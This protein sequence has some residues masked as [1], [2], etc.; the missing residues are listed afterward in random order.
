MIGQVAAA[1]PGCFSVQTLA[2]T[3]ISSAR[4]QHP[5]SRVLYA[6]GE[7][8]DVSLIRIYVTD[9]CSKVVYGRPSFTITF[10]LYNYLQLII[11]TVTCIRIKYKITDFN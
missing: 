10:K 6:T 11:E 9:W 4:W 8:G 1:F 5:Y 3:A 2:A 7:S